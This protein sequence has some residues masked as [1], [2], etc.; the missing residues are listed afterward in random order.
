MGVSR[1][2]YS[3]LYVHFRDHFCPECSAKLRVIK[4]SKVVNSKSNEAKYFDFRGVD[5]TSMIGDV[6]FI[7]NEFKCPKCGLQITV[8][9][10]KLIE[11]E[12]KKRRRDERKRK[13][14]NEKQRSNKI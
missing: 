4:I 9:A 8:Q 7:W 13:K 6:N 10:M 5:G 1:T 2:F 12:Q 11:R 3:P 14:A